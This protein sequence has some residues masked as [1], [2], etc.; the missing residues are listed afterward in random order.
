M[1]Y[2]RLFTSRTATLIVSHQSYSLRW[3]LFSSCDVSKERTTFYQDLE[4]SQ[5]FLTSHI[6][7]FSPW[8]VS[9]EAKF[10]PCCYGFCLHPK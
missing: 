6:F 5:D 8:Q 9:A 2:Y 1:H 3:K 4:A 7:S 10:F